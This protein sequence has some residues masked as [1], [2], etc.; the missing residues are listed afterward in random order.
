[1]GEQQWPRHGEF[2]TVGQPAPVGALRAMVEA[3]REGVVAVDGEGRIVAANGAAVA[4]VGAGLGVGATLTAALPIAAAPGRPGLG[5]A[6]QA[7]LRGGVGAIE[8]R[9]ELARPG[10]ERGMPLVGRIVP[11]RESGAV[12]GAVI[13]LCGGDP[14]REA[15][16]LVDLTERRFERFFDHAPIG[17]SMTAPDGRLLRVNRALGERLGRSVDEMQSS[18]YAPITHPEDLAETQTAMARILTG[19]TESA[20]FEKRFLHSDGHYVWT[21]VTSRLERDDDGKPLFFVTHIQDISEL[22]A[23]REAIEAS[24]RELEQFAYAA[25]HDLQEPLR[26]VASFT[27]LLAK[28]YGPQLDDDAREFIG[29]AVDGAQR[30]QRLIHD[31]LSY[32]RV[33]TRGQALGPVALG[34]ALGEALVALQAAVRES[35]GSVVQGDLPVVLGDAVQLTQVFQ[36]LIG[37]ALKFHRPGVPPEVHVSAEVNEGRWVVAVRDNGIGVEPRYFDRIFGIFQRLHT[38]SEY[39]G[40]GLGLALCQRILH[41]HGGRLWVES[42]PGEGATFFFSLSSAP[43]APARGPEASP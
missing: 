8:V 3:V 17:K 25:S 23:K 32:A 5:E 13:T 2:R 19:E 10:A 43:D 41:R 42:V 26:M 9:G 30:M 28:R 16:H 24:N 1:M 36:N 21:Q 34:A 4:L 22:R 15:R 29:F 39:P 33:S 35:G 14:D 18:S 20:V 6:V 27:Q 12:A 37:N 40:T 7:V 38:Q 11:W 31:L